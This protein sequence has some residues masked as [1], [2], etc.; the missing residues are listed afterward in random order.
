MKIYIAFAT[1]FMFAMSSGFLTSILLFGYQ[2]GVNRGLE[3]SSTMIAYTMMT[4][5]SFRNLLLFFSALNYFL[6]L[7]AVLKRADEI[8]CLEENKKY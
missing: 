6:R 2:I 4:Y 3:Y 8:L 7:L 1:G 5:I